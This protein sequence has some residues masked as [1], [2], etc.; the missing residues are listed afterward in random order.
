MHST[1]WWLTA[2]KQLGREEP[3]GPG[4]RQVEHEPALCPCGK[5]G[6]LHPG[7]HEGKCCQQVEESDSSCL[8]S[9]G[10]THPECWVQFWV[11]QHKGDL[12]IL[13]WDQ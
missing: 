8:L 1:G 5:G 12:D 2:A 7:L 13:E 10:E 6:Q 11:P 9:M 3:G 4:R